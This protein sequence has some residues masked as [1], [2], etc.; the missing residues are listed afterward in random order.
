MDHS[1]IY[2][3]L[4][5]GGGIPRLA[6]RKRLAGDV[7]KSVARCRGWIGGHHVSYDPAI[8][9]VEAG[10]NRHP[11]IAV[12]HAPGAA[13]RRGHAHGSGLGAGPVQAAAGRE[14]ECAVSIC[15][16]SRKGH[17]QMVHD[18]LAHWRW[19][20]LDLIHAPIIEIDQHRS[21]Q[22]QCIG[23]IVG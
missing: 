17:R 16:R 14:I 5:V 22:I 3:R 10:G 19:D 23:V 1:K 13:I 8:G 4:S 12:G 20:E 9:V 2:R 11:G 21:G 18:K 7:D 6:E 15:V